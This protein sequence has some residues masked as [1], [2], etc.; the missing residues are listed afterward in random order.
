MPVWES[1]SKQ[2]EQCCNE[3]SPLL[4]QVPITG[5]EGRDLPREP[6]AQL[7]EKAVSPAKLRWIMASVWI[8]TFC[9]GLGEHCLLYFLLDS[10]PHR[11]YLVDYR[12]GDTTEQPNN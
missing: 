12:Q 7:E 4:S 9:A 6:A 11:E 3:T 8:G 10:P 2:D 5:L 1:T